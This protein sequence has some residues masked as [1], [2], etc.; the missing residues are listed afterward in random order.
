M[1]IEKAQDPTIEMR[2]PDTASYFVPSAE[3]S[4]QLAA[5]L[6]QRNLLFL[7]SAATEISLGVTAALCDVLRTK[8]GVPAE[9]LRD[10]SLDH[11]SGAAGAETFLARCN[12]SVDDLISKAQAIV[13]ASGKSLNNHYIFADFEEGGAA[14]S[15]RHLWLFLN[16]ANSCATLDARL[17]KAG[18]KLV[19][20][21]PFEW[22]GAIAR[23]AG[24]DSQAVHQ[25][26][27]EA[28]IVRGLYR[29]RVMARRDDDLSMAELDDQ[30]GTARATEI[31][32]YT[33]EAVSKSFEAQNKTYSARAYCELLRS[34][35]AELN[36]SELADEKA[37]ES[38]ITALLRDADEES[39]EFKKFTTIL[40][41]RTEPKA[42]M[43][44]VMGRFGALPFREFGRVCTTL[45][46]ARDQKGTYRPAATSDSP[47]GGISG[48]NYSFGGFY[49]GDQT[50]DTRHKSGDL[51][52]EFEHKADTLRHDLHLRQR[53]QIGSARG[54]EVVFINPNHQK[55]IAGQLLDRFAS[56]TS[57]TMDLLIEG[58]YGKDSRLIEH[59]V[60]P[61]AGYIGDAGASEEVACLL[62]RLL[63]N[64][65]EKKVY[66][67][68]ELARTLRAEKFYGS[69]EAANH[70]CAMVMGQLL[71]TNHAGRAV[72]LFFEAL[73][74]AGAYEEYHA[75]ARLLDQQ[76]VDFDGP[77]Y[78][79]RLISLKERDIE[80]AV[81]YPDDKSDGTK[82]ESVK[83]KAHAAFDKQRSE[84]ILAIADDVAQTQ[85]AA[86]RYISHIDSVLSATEDLGDLARL[87]AAEIALTILS[88]ATC[89]MQPMTDGSSA[90]SNAFVNR[91]LFGTPEDQI[92]FLRILRS[93]SLREV[94]VRS[95][96]APNETDAMEKAG[97]QEFLQNHLKSP[98]GDDGKEDPILFRRLW[99]EMLLWVARPLGHFD[100]VKNTHLIKNAL[101]SARLA[102]WSK[103]FEEGIQAAH[104]G[105]R[106]FYFSVQRYFEGQDKGHYDD[107]ASLPYLIVLEWWL[108]ARGIDTDDEAANEDAAEALMSNFAGMLSRED[109]GEINTSEARARHWNDLAAT[110][111]RALLDR[112]ESRNMFHAA[113][114]RKRDLTYEFYRELTAHL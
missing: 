94:I 47:L 76:S 23:W 51:V 32:E 40:A 15:L 81:A 106:E 31:A 91:H 52:A 66:D 62:L 5:Q 60:D 92:R 87:N 68:T 10:F 93:E 114:A 44:F 2:T 41:E 109:Y 28:I 78:I 111:A 77:R 88:R 73:L 43:L 50:T 95:L 54:Q 57:S 49:S 34:V 20:F 7:A 108:L 25:I 35:V 101:L 48:I 42:T 39:E 37:W 18:L 72:D 74:K 56:Y 26:A 65:P 12:L 53:R 85:R 61:L 64:A 11:S 97:Q 9:N 107:L 80:D 22:Q 99:S 55:M 19:V 33:K 1:H 58:K 4:T 79:L 38:K 27:P 46:R 105:D 84:F 63:W 110:Q 90:T 21:C 102:A 86:E 14:M 6:A 113:Y 100:Q 67:P 59:L 16:D 69:R 13:G 82:Q 29:Q 75:V 71:H 45:L 104:A 8:V 98:E 24:D 30:L 17:G 83:E 103:A 3:I 89:D 70:L 96:T 36:G 112:A